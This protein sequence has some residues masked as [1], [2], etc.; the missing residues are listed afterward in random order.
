MGRGRKIAFDYG[1]ARIGVA[2][3]DPDGILAS[4]LPFLDAKHPKLLKQ[5]ETI[6]EEYE[7][8]TIFI[9]LPKN[10][11]GTDGEAVT[12]AKAFS[13]RL[14]TISTLPIVFIDERLSTVG[15]QKRL[16]EAGKNAKESR[17]LIDS[18]SAVAILESGLARE[19]Q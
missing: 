5:I 14:L 2:I 4:P 3:C 12:K 9:G 7:P 16:H 6:L 13:E 1:D 8:I 10:L 17:L 15:A 18:M 11:S 19:A